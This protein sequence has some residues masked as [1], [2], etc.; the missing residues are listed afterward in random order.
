MH[1]ICLRL[2]EHVFKKILFELL[3]DLLIHFYILLVFYNFNHL[4]PAILFYTC[5]IKYKDIQ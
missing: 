5:T 1:V 2:Y 4:F 3:A